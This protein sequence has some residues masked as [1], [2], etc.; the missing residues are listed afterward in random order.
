ASAL[1]QLR[2]VVRG[3][4]SF[5]LA[6]PHRQPVAEQ[7]AVGRFGGLQQRHHPL[8]AAHTLGRLLRAVDAP[9]FLLLQRRQP[10]A[11]ATIPHREIPSSRAGPSLRLHSKPYVQKVSLASRRT[12]PRAMKRSRS[13]GSLAPALE[14]ASLA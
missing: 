14:P 1:Q 7:L 10:A 12:P 8:L 11:I 2:R 6:G 13:Q 3:D 5:G 4:L 9:R